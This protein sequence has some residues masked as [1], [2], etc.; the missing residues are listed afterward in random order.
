MDYNDI[1]YVMQENQLS[2][3]LG[4]LTIL[5]TSISILIAIITAISVATYIF[6]A[7]GF[8]TL[9]KKQN[10]DYRFLLWIPFYSV[11]CAPLYIMG[12][13]I[14]EEVVIGPLKLKKAHI[15]LPIGTVVTVIVL[16]IINVI[17]NLISLLEG[18]IIIAVVLYIAVFAACILWFVLYFAAYYSLYKLY[19]PDYAVLFLVLSIFFP[20]I[21]P[22]FVFS[23]RNREPISIVG[24]QAN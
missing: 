12:K 3:M 11:T 19:N 22:F 9:A 10:I 24:K 6:Q 14:G 2:G 7:I 1:P 15:W 21:I 5:L 8:H 16:N 20:Y 4:S 13:L 17:A 18:G 23:F